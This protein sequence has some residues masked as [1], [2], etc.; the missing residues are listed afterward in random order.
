M[1]FQDRGSAFTFYYTIAVEGT[2]GFQKGGL[3][4][5]RPKRRLPYERLMRRLGSKRSPLFLAFA[6]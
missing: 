4:K 6:R 3:R 5:K 2:G 1:L